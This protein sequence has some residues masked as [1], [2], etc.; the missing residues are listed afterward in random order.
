MK[1][2]F[3]TLIIS[4]LVLITVM[5]T[6]CVKK[7]ESSSSESAP[8]PTPP[9]MENPYYQ[10]TH[11][12]TAPE[13]ADNDQR[14]IIK[15]GELLYT[16]VVPSAPT[17]REKIAQEEFALLLKRATGI[18]PNVITDA[19]I[20]DYNPQGR[21][22]SIGQT[23]ILE[24][25]LEKSGR[26]IDRAALKSNGARLI[27]ID[28][29]IFLAGGVADVAI[30]AVY[31]FFNICF[32]YEW[33]GRNNLYIDDTKKDLKLRLFDVIDIPDIN[34]HQITYGPMA[35]ASE[36]P[37][38]IDSKALASPYLNASDIY[39]E[40]NVKS[41]RN[42]YGGKSEYRISFPASG[43]KKGKDSVG[44]QHNVLNIFS[45]HTAEENGWDWDDKW[46]ADSGNQICWTAHGDIDAYKRMV[47]FAV[48]RVIGYMK[49]YPPKDWPDMS[50]MMFGVE[51]G[52]T[53]CRCGEGDEDGDGRNENG[54]YW[55]EQRDGAHVG[56][57]IRFV[58]LV[59]DK[60]R[61]W[62]DD[63]ANAKYYREEFTIVLFAYNDSST[64]PTHKDE[65][66]E[67][68]ANEGIYEG[69]EWLVG[70]GIFEGGADQFRD[71]MFD[72]LAIW[73]TFNGPSYLDI[74]ADNKGTK[75][76]VEQF[77]AWSAIFDDVFAWNY[78]EFYQN[79]TYFLDYLS[80]W[81]SNMVQFY[82]SMGMSHMITELCGGTYGSV[83]AWGDLYFYMITKLSWDGSLSSTELISKF[84]KA[85]YGPAAET[86]EK[87]YYAQKKHFQKIAGEQYSTTGTNFSIGKKVWSEA[88]YPY[89]VI[90][91]FINY[92]DQAYEDIKDYKLLNS[93]MY[94]V[95]KDRIDVE[96][97]SHYKA[98]LEIHNG[99]VKPYTQEEKAIYRARAIEL[100]NTRSMKQ[101]TL[102]EFLAW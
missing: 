61:A 79:H 89:H 6:A 8:A 27:T 9:T 90:K 4:L 45:K 17:K 18:I 41:V 22:I 25:A 54:C 13:V 82:S 14:Y 91:G 84:M 29:N 59:Y 78:A 46:I 83:T 73:K 98:L 88:E 3:K 48:M 66:G 68:V 92:I 38:V 72:N 96:G 100:L 11:I 47:D 44:S 34:T 50:K 101:L 42:R 1:K 58:R 56:S 32:D 86:M 81:N 77:N 97:V 33:Y 36:N 52:G 70:K 24:E 12:Y 23:S 39:K 2:I 62:M 60:L 5:T 71:R 102:E 40:I 26:T 10:G 57:A 16:V 7:E 69:M 65:N 93:D 64:P 15:N 30:N 21:Y 51:D 67:W 31:D 19:E 99:A 76:V 63:P 94:D 87:L 74:T 75:K 80:E 85:H 37:T 53:V 43:Y 35:K 55:S 95:Y 49:S 20:T 28:D